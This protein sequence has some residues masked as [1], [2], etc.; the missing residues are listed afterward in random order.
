MLHVDDLI[1]PGAEKILLPRLDTLW[2]PH[3]TPPPMQVRGRVNHKSSLQGIPLH[4]PNFR[5]IQLRKNAVSRFQINDLGIL[6]GRRRSR[7]IRTH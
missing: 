5:Q 1:E 3:R 4:R 6:H 7:L 2:W